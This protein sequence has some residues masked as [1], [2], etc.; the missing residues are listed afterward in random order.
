M[1]DELICYGCVRDTYLIK[2]IKKSGV[3]F[4]CSV[5]SKKRK[6]I[7]VDDLISRVDDVLQQYFFPG[8]EYPKFTDGG[9]FSHYE[10][11]GDYLDLHIAEMLGLD[12]DDPVVERV[13]GELTS[14]SQYDYMQGGEAKYHDDLRYVTRVVRPFHAEQRWNDFRLD[15]KHGNRYFNKNA[16]RFLDWLFDGL[17]LFRGYDSEAVVRELFEEEIFR[18]RRCDSTTEYDT[19]AKD[20]ANQL[21]AP[22]KERAGSG[23]MNPAG[24]PAFYGAFERDTCVAELRPP[25]GGRVISGKFKL[26]RAAQVFDFIALDRAYAAQPLSFLDPNYAEKKGRRDFLRTLH[27]KIKVPVL[28]DQEHEYLITQVI[29]EYLATQYKVPI[30]GVLF[31]SV[32]VESGTNLTLFNHAVVAQEPSYVLVETLDQLAESSE[33]QSS[34]LKYVPNSLMLHRVQKVSFSTQ[35]VR[36]NDGDPEWV[37]YEEDWYDG[38]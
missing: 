33:R 27:S 32:Q 14:C 10:Q 6:G 1:D 28:P 34:A 18:A 12:E 19:I 11:R 21:G 30:D 24:V 17:D 25:V 26:T 15:I 22:P 13:C 35:D 3:S 9:S 8:D 37:D 20:A 7:A 16:K 31:A 29:A 38:A 2:Q 4:E 36:R 23:R 5:C